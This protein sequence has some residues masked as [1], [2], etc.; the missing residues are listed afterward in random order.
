MDFGTLRGRSVEERTG[1][2]S[3]VASSIGFMAGD[4]EVGVWELC[5]VEVV[6]NTTKCDSSSVA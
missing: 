5:G 2:I 3:C 4:V 6:S 1:E